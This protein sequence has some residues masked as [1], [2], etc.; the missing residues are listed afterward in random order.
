MYADADELRVRIGETVFDEIY[1]EE[2]DAV[3]DLTDAEA[4]INGCIGRRYAR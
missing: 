3:T 2:T 4:E 1:S